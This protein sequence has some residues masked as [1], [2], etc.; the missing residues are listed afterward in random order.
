MHGECGL[1]GKRGVGA[2]ACIAGLCYVSAQGRS[3]F[4]G[5][6]GDGNGK[7][8]A[9]G[10]ICG[11]PDSGLGVFSYGSSAACVLK[12]PVAATRKDD[13]FV[14]GFAASAWTAGPSQ[15]R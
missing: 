6:A 11:T 8:R 10:G 14:A 12:R 1:A 4:A 9:N 3:A 7:Q 2:G 5:R 13:G 15:V